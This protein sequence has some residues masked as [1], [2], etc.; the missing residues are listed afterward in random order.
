MAI[1]IILED[2]GEDVAA[3]Y[4]DLTK[5]AKNARRDYGF[6]PELHRWDFELPEHFIEKEPEAAVRIAQALLEEDRENVKLAVNAARIY[7]EAGDPENGTDLLRRFSGKLGR[8]YWYEWGTCAGN[9]GDAS[10]NAVLAAFELTD[11][12]LLSPDIKT[13]TLVL[14]GLGRALSELYKQFG[15]G[16]FAMAGSSSAWL[17]LKLPYDSKANNFYQIHKSEAD[18]K[19]LAEPK[20]LHGALSQLKEGI[21]AAWEVSAIQHTLLEKSVHQK[22]IALLNWATV[23]TLRTQMKL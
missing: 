15:D 23:F 18:A 6:V 22:H 14:S 9:T 8:G 12:V 10:S 11:Q 21:V 5:A 20:D 2:Y 13:A 17:G 16:R 4:V 7:R 19:G 1:S 3:R